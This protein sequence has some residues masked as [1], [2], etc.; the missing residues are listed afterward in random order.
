ME[1]STGDS[2]L[3]PEQVWDV[4]DLPGRE[5][6]TGK[7]SGSACPLVWAHSEYIKLRRSL[8]DGRIFDQPPQTVDRYLTKKKSSEYFNWRFN[9]KPRTIPCGKK[10]R[11]LLM[12]PALVHWSFD[13]WQTA[14]DHDS[15][16][17]GWNLQH[18]D[19]PTETLA[20]GRQITFTFYWK[21]SGRWEQ[22][23]YQVTV[24]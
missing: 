19:L 22:R 10:L 7:A 4:Q 16:E 18:L 8:L 9:N 21:T 1:S 11:L 15:E 17:S 13:N 3:I 5:L 2:R 20:V 12:E 6:F 23:D 14:K 24:E